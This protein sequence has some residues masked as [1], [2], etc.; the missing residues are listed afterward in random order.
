MDDKDKQK[1]KVPF[2]NIFVLYTYTRKKTG[3]GLITKVQRTSTVKNTSK[4]SH[5]VTSDFQTTAY[6]MDISTNSTY[7]NLSLCKVIL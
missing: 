5:Y 1:N 3:K 4:S 7:I 2:E 6:W